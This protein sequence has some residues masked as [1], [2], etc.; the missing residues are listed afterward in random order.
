MV[1]LTRPQLQGWNWTLWREYAAS[2]VDD[3]CNHL[4]TD[5]DTS[6][7]HVAQLVLAGV[8]ACYETWRGLH[9]TYTVPRERIAIPRTDLSVTELWK[10]IVRGLTDLAFWLW[11]CQRCTTHE[12]WA[13]HEQQRAVQ[14]AGWSVEV[15]RRAASPTN[16]ELATILLLVSNTLHRATVAI[17]TKVVTLLPSDKGNNVCKLT[18][19]VAVT[20]PPPSLVWACTATLREIDDVARAAYAAVADFLGVPTTVLGS[21]VAPGLTTHGTG[22]Q[23]HIAAADA[24]DGRATTAVPPTHNIATAP[25]VG[26]ATVSAPAPAPVT[27]SV[28]SVAPMQRSTAA[29]VSSIPT[30]QLVNP[31]TDADLAA[32]FAQ[33]Y[34][35]NFSASQVRDKEAERRAEYKYAAFTGDVRPDQDNVELPWGPS[36]STP[37]NHLFPPPPL[38]EAPVL[39][40]Q[41]VSTTTTAAA[42]EAAVE[43]APLTASSVPITSRDDVAPNASAGERSASLLKPVVPGGEARTPT[44]APSVT[45]VLHADTAAP[46]AHITP[47]PAASTTHFAAAAPVLPMGI[48]QTTTANAECVSATEHAVTTACHDHS[49]PMEGVLEPS[50][51]PIAAMQGVMEARTI[52]MPAPA[53]V[54][55]AVFSAA[56][57]DAA[58][59]EPPAAPDVTVIGEVVAATVPPAVPS[60]AMV[61]LA[62]TVAVVQQLIAHAAHDQVTVLVEATTEPPAVSVNPTA[63]VQPA[64]TAA[65]VVA[66]TVDAAAAATTEPHA[67]PVVAAMLDAAAT[68]EPHAALGTATRAITTTGVG[69]PAAAGA[70]PEP[71][72]Y[73]DSFQ[74]AGGEDEQDSGAELPPHDHPSVIRHNQHNAP[75][76]M[77]DATPVGLAQHVTEI[78]ARVARLMSQVQQLQETNARLQAAM[79]LDDLGAQPAPRAPVRRYPTYDLPAGMTVQAAWLLYCCGGEDHAP[80]MVG[81]SDGTLRL[82]PW[83]VGTRFRLVMSTIKDCLVAL[84]EWQDTPTAADAT[85]WLGDPRLAARVLGPNVKLRGSFALSALYTVRNHIMRRRKLSASRAA[86]S[87]TANITEVDDNP[88]PQ[89]TTTVAVAGDATEAGRD[90]ATH[91]SDSSSSHIETTAA[92][93]V[94]SVSKAAAHGT[95]KPR[96]NKQPVP[97]AAAAASAS[98]SRTPSRGKRKCH[99]E[100][101]PPVAKRAR[102]ARRGRNGPAIPGQVAPLATDVPVNATN[103]AV[104]ATRV[105]TAVDASAATPDDVDAPPG[106]DLTARS[107]R[108]KRRQDDGI[109]GT[110]TAKRVRC[111]G[112]GTQEDTATQD[113]PAA[114]ASEIAFVEAVTG[115]SH[116]HDPT[117]AAASAATSDGTAATDGGEAQHGG[118]KRTAETAE[119]DENAATGKRAQPAAD[120]DDAGTTQDVTASSAHADATVGASTDSAPSH[121][122]AAA[123]ASATTL[124]HNPAAS[125]AQ[126]QRRSQ[127]TADAAEPEAA[128]AS[129]KRRRLAADR[130]DSGVATTDHCVLALVPAP[131]QYCKPASSA[132]N[133]FVMRQFARRLHVVLP[134][135]DC[136]VHTLSFF[137]GI[138][139]CV[140]R[141]TAAVGIAICVAASAQAAGAD[142]STPMTCDGDEFASSAVEVEG[143]L[144]RYRVAD[145]EAGTKA[146]AV[147]AI[148][149]VLSKGNHEDAPVVSLLCRILRLPL[150]VMMVGNQEDSSQWNVAPLWT[151]A[152]D[153]SDVEWSADAPAA[154][155]LAVFYQKHYSPCVLVEPVDALTVPPCRGFAQVVDA[156][157]ADVAALPPAVL[158]HRSTGS[159]VQVCVICVCVCVCVRVRV[160]VSFMLMRLGDDGDA[161]TATHPVS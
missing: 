120:V 90:G 86:A 83:D 74:E 100:V 104:V 2:V 113:P 117:A 19:T 115:D 76:T 18:A 67:A 75:T 130:D 109:A 44:A 72:V 154:V 26:G 36:A 148:N 66:A 80:L 99:E 16:V 13:A 145:D 144:S 150:A 77:V 114:A 123:D 142:A 132:V 29:P 105:T 45:K 156:L 40:R 94:P 107:A 97:A 42:A 121:T 122:T 11:G 47:T 139:W 9:S 95:P 84:L 141:W 50:A 60:A 127:R 41:Q 1:C 151:R 106:S 55:T 25:V 52:T 32:R 59:T 125:G 111:T 118:E 6:V 54:A 160:V 82:A 147:T 23:V 39:S 79:H 17:G 101:P 62:T 102:T 12:D 53:E 136:S 88:E 81:L 5:Q 24:I 56:T 69:A 161:K 153:G 87:A 93:A 157:C 138:P 48:A 20:A 129:G 65:P 8:T 92:S 135:G 158:A 78:D 119:L 96:G 34:V 137:T 7:A 98:T 46:P 146:A 35:A 110:P 38:R 70:L 131:V 89:N 61:A 31:E 3:A 133:V 116:G 43:D 155:R 159:D 21:V 33:Q 91:D 63:V 71:E 4:A 49:A 140:L 28:D 15:F 73:S 143:L 149:A 152:A 85:A 68:T 10:R 51:A 30:G 57:E 128:A 134:D 103:A 108:A 58:T 22:Q 37:V 112:N 14:V 124:H 64:L 126:A 27:A